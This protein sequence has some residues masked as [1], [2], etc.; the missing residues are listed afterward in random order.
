MNMNVEHPKG[1]ELRAPKTLRARV[2][3]PGHPT[4]RSRLVRYSVMTLA[5]GG[6]AFLLSHLSANV[7]LITAGVVVIAAAA[8]VAWGWAILDIPPW[9]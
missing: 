3:V 8:L 5:I 2:N 6:G 4:K 1:V 7:L 9:A